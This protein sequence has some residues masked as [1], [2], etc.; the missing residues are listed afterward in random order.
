MTYQEKITIENSSGLHARPA[1]SFCNAASR[2]VSDIK[3]SKDDKPLVANA[4]S[5]M[6]LLA[7]GI[8]QGDVV[9]IS[10]DGADAEEAVK[11]LVELVKTKFGE[12]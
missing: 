9:T 12:D 8:S 5:I 1:S 7:L 6:F 2:F 11:T 4:K 3:I 10:A